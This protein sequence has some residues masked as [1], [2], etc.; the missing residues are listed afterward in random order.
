VN[1]IQI[2]YDPAGGHMVSFD[3]ERFD[4]LPQAPGFGSR[5]RRT[6]VPVAPVRPDRPGKLAEY[7]SRVEHARAH[8][9]RSEIRRRDRR[10]A[11]TGRDPIRMRGRTRPR[12]LEITNA[13][14]SLGPAFARAG[15]AVQRL[16]EEFEPALAAMQQHINE[17]VQAAA[18]AS[19]PRRFMAGASPEWTLYDDVAAYRRFVEADLTESERARREQALAG[20]YITVDDLRRQMAEAEQQ[21]AE[22][23]EHYLRAFERIRPS[24]MADGGSIRPRELPRP[25]LDDHGNFVGM[26]TPDVRSGGFISPSRALDNDTIPVRLG[27]GEV[28]VSRDALDRYGVEFFQRL[29]GVHDLT[30]VRDEAAGPDVVH[31]YPMSATGR[32]V[33]PCPCSH[34]RSTSAVRLRDITHHDRWLGEGNLDRD[35]TSSVHS[36]DSSGTG[37]V[38]S[39]LMTRIDNLIEE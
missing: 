38:W 24:A 11:R 3:G 14:A 15:Q 36:T 13:M 37:A 5:C 31:V 10:R 2:G 27:V 16:A 18:M 26:R 32:R 21:D 19:V 33:G 34:C 4:M 12:M 35:E 30:E 20:P 22:L 29:N 39:D 25:V 8:R 17:V 28:R 7:P 6:V 23:A 9:L 1:R